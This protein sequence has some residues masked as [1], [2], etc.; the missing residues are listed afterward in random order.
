MSIEA[1]KQ[2]HS[3]RHNCPHC[4][5]EFACNHHQ[6]LG[7]T[8]EEIIEECYGSDEMNGFVEGARWANEKLKELNT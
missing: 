5:R 2:E 7:L 8:D 1:M 6:W 4:E 3:K